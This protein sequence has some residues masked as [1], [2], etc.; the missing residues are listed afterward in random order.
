MQS[1]MA[2][3]HMVITTTNLHSAAAATSSTVGIHHLH[4]HVPVQAGGFHQ[5][6]PCPTPNPCPPH[7]HPPQCATTT[8]IPQSFAP[9]PSHPHLP[10]FHP[11]PGDPYHHQ[12]L[13]GGCIPPPF[14]HP[15]PK[16]IHFFNPIPV[17]F[18]NTITSVATQTCPIPMI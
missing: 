14:P 8:G 18:G 4:H 13:P 15:D 17:T 7:P 1:V 11:I 5:H 9:P 10:P 3:H 16:D 6:W 2:Q 12:I